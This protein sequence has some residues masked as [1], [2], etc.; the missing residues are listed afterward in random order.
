MDR[1]EW[2]VKMKE[3]LAAGKPLCKVSEEPMTAAE[4]KEVG[5]ARYY[6]MFMYV[7]MGVGL[8]GFPFLA[9]EDELTKFQQYLIASLIFV[10]Y[11]YLIVM[12]YL[13]MMKAY[14]GTK[15]VII[16]FITEKSKE[17]AKRG[18]HYYFTIGAD[19]LIEVD[20]NEY[21]QYEVGDA[22]EAH[23]FVNWGL[24]LLSL[25]RIEISPDSVSG[26]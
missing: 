18:Y 5:G 15:E 7:L 19:K 13:K 14:N 12:V 22:V 3:M 23:E 10:G 1:E 20:I 17:S 2:L 26:S 25:K 6:Q 16:G 8:V 21:R 4:R 9:K 11:G 24:V